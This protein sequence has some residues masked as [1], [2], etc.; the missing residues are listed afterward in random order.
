MVHHELAS[1]IKEKAKELGFF[2]CG[3]RMASPFEE[4]L[5]NVKKRIS[6]FPE[7]KALYE[8]LLQY[9]YPQRSAEWAKSIV[10]CISH[11]GKFRIPPGTKNL[12]GKFYLVDGRLPY[13]EEHAASQQFE[14]WLRES[15]LRTLKRCCL[16]QDG[17][18]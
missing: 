17:Q 2:A 9:G 11:Y 6:R 5:E 13:S 4:F 10:V 16:Q 18:P 8:K 15:G 1:K 7:S 12:V 3:I 14:A